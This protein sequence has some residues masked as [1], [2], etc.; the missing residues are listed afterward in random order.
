MNQNDPQNR[1]EQEVDLVPVFVWIGD[2][3]KG[4][5]R[6]IGN[7]FKAIGHAIILFLIFLQKNIILIG[8]FILVGIGLGYYLDSAGKS[9]YTAQL[10]VQPNFNSSSQLISNIK[11]YNSLTDEGDYDRLANALGLSLDEAK[12][13]KSFSIEESYNDTELLAEYDRLARDSDTM[14]LDNF[15]FEGFKEAKREIDYE[16]YEIIA[17]AE[18]RAILEKAIPKVIDIKENSGIKAARLSYLENTEFDIEAKKYQLSEIDSLI[19]A[20]QKMISTEKSSSGGNTNLFVGDQRSS[21]NLAN[22]FYQKQTLLEDLQALREDKYAS[23]NIVNVVSEYIVKGNVK[24]E[25]IKLKLILVFFFLGIFVASIP[26]LWRF[27]NTYSA[28][29]P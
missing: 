8:L 14:A 24:N 1:E 21:D 12:K 5:F 16:F 29:N 2:G 26:L 9:N 25:H 7:F 6:A 17:K 10:R 11:Y 19:A 22:L 13:L 28:K 4:F 15:T 3:I 23:E 18:T 27:L 20:Y